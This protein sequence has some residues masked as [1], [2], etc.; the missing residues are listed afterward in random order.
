LKTV[1]ETYMKMALELAEQ[2][3]GW[4]SPNPM[5]GA[6][7]V[8]DGQVVGK[9]FH[10][11]AGEPHAEVHALN[12]AGEKAR[13]ATLYVSLEPCNHDGR[14]PPC[15][16]AI[17][18]HGIRRV[19]AGMKDPNPAV[20]GG[21]MAFLKSRGLDVTIGVCENLCRRLNEA[22]IKYVTTSLPFVILKCAATLDGSIATH[23]G[24]SKWITNVLSRH[25]VH[26]LRHAVDAIMVGIGT[27]L[28]DDPQL[29]TRLEGRRGADPM[30]VILDTHL[31]I[32]PDARLLHLQSASDTL[33][34]TGR[35]ASAEKRSRLEKPGIRFLALDHDR[36]KVDLSALMKELG[37]LEVTSLL[38]EGGSTLNGSALR[39]GIVDK[40]H[41]FY[42]PKLCAGQGIPVCG[43][44][45]VRLMEQSIRVADLS[46]HRFGDDVMIEGYL[47]S[48]ST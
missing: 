4:T 46:V 7:I 45:G 17:L 32:P 14:T 24:D 29:T 36:G 28:K 12:D 1:D 6:V 38:I 39:A 18:K 21:G 30:R 42:A 23:T 41:L 40:I 25:F 22:F 44:P 26:E 33:I 31:S 35:D 34:V 43:G 13:G 8:K 11:A 5:V 20:T 48:E 2:G 9:G 3:R 15:T 27:V 10:R 47:K 16:H 37:K 19:V